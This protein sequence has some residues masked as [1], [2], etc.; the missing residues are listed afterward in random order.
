MREFSCPF[1]VGF[2]GGAISSAVGYTHFNA[3]RMDG[4]FTL[5]S[6]CFS[7]NQT[8]NVNSGQLYGIPSEQIYSTW[9]DLIAAEKSNLDALIIL[10]PIP[11][12]KEIVVAALKSGLPV[13]CEKA[14]ALSSEEC[15][16]IQKVLIETKGYLAVTLNYSGY[17]MVRQLRE[18]VTEGCLGAL[19][20]III[21]MPQESFLRSESQPQ[22]WRQRDYNIPTVSLDLGV[23]VH[24]LISFITSGK[25]PIKV[26]ADQANYGKL[27]GIVDTVYGIAQYE[28]D[29]RVQMWWGKTALGHRNG[30]RI[31]VFGTKGGAE[32]TQMNPEFLYFSDNTGHCYTL[33]RACNEAKLAQ[34]LRYNRFK[35]GHPSG[36]IEAF[37]NLYTD[38]ADDIAVFKSNSDL[39][40]SFVYGVEH[41]KEG[42]AF[43]E[44]INLSANQSKWVS[45]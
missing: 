39:V 31:R 34:S 7:R 20:Q 5:V 2:V 42:L 9:I 45:I 32:W 4:H 17:P 12:H 21:E 25:R 10:T 1:R 22:A 41:S 3:S 29:L 6:G 44:A 38:I 30:L 26:T 33:D 13:I 11:S 28:D 27:P 16:E 43:M 40:N 19:Q 24:H 37:A 35:A 36:F 23:H 8:E 14:L 15:D 18:M